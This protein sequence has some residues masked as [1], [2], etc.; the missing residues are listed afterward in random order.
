MSDAKN[1]SRRDFLKGASAAAAGLTLA[2]GLN[3]ARSAYAA[4]S[5][6][7]KVSLIGCGGRGWAPC[8]IV[9]TPTTTSS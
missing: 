5:D 8:T 6:E 2:G 7:L 9:S 1:P 3:F 4:G